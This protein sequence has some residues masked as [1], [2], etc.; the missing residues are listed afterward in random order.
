MAHHAPG[1]LPG[2]A[3]F[4]AEHVTSAAD[5][6]YEA[7]P[8]HT[9]RDLIRSLRADLAAR[10]ANEPDN[11]EGY[12]RADAVLREAISSGVLDPNFYDNGSN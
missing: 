4:N 8:G 6:H 3:G 11:L 2:L 1:P 9:E 5:E 7:F 12:E 10:F